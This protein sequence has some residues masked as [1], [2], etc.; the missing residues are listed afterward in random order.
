MEKTN[1]QINKILENFENL[2]NWIF[3][4]SMSCSEI[5]KNIKIIKIIIFQMK[6]QN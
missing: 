2:W 1:F 6:S 4:E 3:V 5:V